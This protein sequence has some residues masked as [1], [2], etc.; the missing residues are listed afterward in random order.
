MRDDG[1]I[2]DDVT[3]TFD[4]SPARSRRWVLWR[5]STEK[6]LVAEGVWISSFAAFRAFS[7]IWALAGIM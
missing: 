4:S 2:P 5:A 1:T 6:R 7:G 3:L